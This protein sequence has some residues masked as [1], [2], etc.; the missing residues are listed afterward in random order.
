MEQIDIFQERYLKHQERKSKL[1]SDSSFGIDKFKKY[2]IKEQETFFEI[3]KNRCSQRAFNNQEVDI[4]P[5]LKAISL[6]PSSCGRK[7]VLIKEVKENKD[8]LSELLVGGKG[9]INKSKVILLLVADMNCYKSPAERDFMPYLDAGILAQT[10][11][12]T[13]EAMNLGCC[14]V[15]PNIRPENQE[16]FKQRFDIKNSQLF[17]G[18]LAIGQYDLKH[19]H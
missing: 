18:A 2:S 8:L 1:L 10:T 5:I 9:W 19:T 4:E 12:L 13:C 6:S 15:N 17:C 16:F 11:Y 7:G 3:L 14:F